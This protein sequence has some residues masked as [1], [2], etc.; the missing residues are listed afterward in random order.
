MVPLFKGQQLQFGECFMQ[1]NSILWENLSISSFN[2]FL[3]MVGQV[4]ILLGVLFIT[5]I[6]I[7]MLAV[8]EN[9]L[10]DSSYKNMN[11]EEIL[12]TNNKDAILS[13]CLNLSTTQFF[14]DQYELC[15]QYS[16]KYVKLTILVLV[17]P[18]IVSLLKFIL[19]EAMKA[20]VTFRRFRY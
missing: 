17:I 4:T 7:F 20:T 6:V 10:Y 2:R 12:K 11:R 19:T 3:R 13:F 1:P 5:I 15:L 16:D 8:F 14:Y 9:T 18:I